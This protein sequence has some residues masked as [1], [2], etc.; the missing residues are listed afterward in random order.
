ML[1]V[2]GMAGKISLTEVIGRRVAKDTGNITT[3]IAN[4]T[5]A[6]IPIFCGVP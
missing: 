4:E 6:V 1:E 3:C 2:Q 5:Q